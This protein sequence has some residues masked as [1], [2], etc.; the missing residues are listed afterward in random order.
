[1]IAVAG[2]AVREKVAPFAA[3]TASA[4]AGPEVGTT[5][6]TAVVPSPAVVIAALAGNPA[7]EAPTSESPSPKANPLRIVFLDMYVSF[8]S[9]FA[10]NQLIT[11]CK[12]VLP[13]TKQEIANPYVDR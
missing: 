3:I 12:R 13:P 5:D 6:K 8:L 4:A 9:W 10:H 7:N 1:M 2:E 11:G